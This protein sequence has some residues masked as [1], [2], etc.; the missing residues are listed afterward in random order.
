MKCS[1]CDEGKEGRKYL[2]QGLHEANICDV[3]VKICS[4]IMKERKEHKNS[5]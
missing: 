1:F 2:F 4:K 3:C 5:T